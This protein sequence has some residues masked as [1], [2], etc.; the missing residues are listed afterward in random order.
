MD[1]EPKTKAT[2]NII[3]T[4]GEIITWAVYRII[5]LNHLNLLEMIMI[6]QLLRDE[7]REE[8]KQTRQKYSS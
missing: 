2:K 3:G 6:I 4:M 5:L 7:K 1:T 8:I